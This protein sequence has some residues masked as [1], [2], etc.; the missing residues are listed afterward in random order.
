M[1]RVGKKAKNLQGLIGNFYDLSR[2]EMND[3]HLHMEKLDVVHFAKEASL[4]FYQE[5]EKRKISV[6]F[7]VPKNPLY[8]LVDAGGNGTYFQQYAAECPA[9]CREQSLYWYFGAGE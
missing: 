8:L 6:Q 3:Y 4:L 9:L 2:L 1:E 5:F 7:D